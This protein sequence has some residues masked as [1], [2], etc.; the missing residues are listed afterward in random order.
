MLTFLTCPDIF[1]L[2]N[3][4]LQRGCGGRC[5][6]LLHKVICWFVLPATMNDSK[7]IGP[8]CTSGYYT[9]LTSAPHTPAAPISPEK[10]V[11]C[12]RGLSTPAQVAIGA[13]PSLISIT[14]R[15]NAR[16]LSECVRTV[17][18]SA[19]AC[20]LHENG[21]HAMH[22][23]SNACKCAGRPTCQRYDA[24]WRL[25]AYGVNCQTT[26]TSLNMSFDEPGLRLWEQRFR[27]LHS[28]VTGRSWL[29]RLYV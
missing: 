19:I 8:N 5:Q 27:Y 9:P 10:C 17:A 28:P 22:R 12:D 3:A 25:G 1:S 6:V 2:Q 11:A 23:C 29:C 21:A 14:S 15:V 7:L 4:V 24:Y 13:C 16:C 18:F 20:C 26:C